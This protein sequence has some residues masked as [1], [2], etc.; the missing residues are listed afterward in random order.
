MQVRLSDAG[1]FRFD[2]SQVD[3]LAKRFCR[4]RV[5]EGAAAVPLVTVTNAFRVGQSMTCNRRCGDMIQTNDF[6]ASNFDGF[7]QW[8]R[9]THELL[10]R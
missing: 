6:S 10:R 1:L 2:V 7:D 5:Y 9:R 8:V 3:E 4:V